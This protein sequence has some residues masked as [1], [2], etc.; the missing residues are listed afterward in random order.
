MGL[1]FI[2][3]ESPF[4]SMDL[5]KDPKLEQQCLYGI[6][7]FIRY[8]TFSKSNEQELG[9][10]RSTF[11][12]A[13]PSFVAPCKPPTE[14]QINPNGDTQSTV[15]IEPQQPTITVPNYK[16]VFFNLYHRF[17]ESHQPVAYVLLDDYSFMLPEDK[18]IPKRPQFDVD[19]KW[20]VT[21]V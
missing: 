18:P 6:S 17:E 13:H 20:N 19:E 2:P 21:F 16:T 7:Q 4:G 15:P 12:I 5:Y 10:Y 14:S 8:F 9:P 11:N 1:G 3:P